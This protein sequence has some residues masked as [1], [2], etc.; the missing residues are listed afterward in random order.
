MPR[1]RFHGRLDATQCAPGAMIYHPHR[2]QV[3]K[4]SRAMMRQSMKRRS[5]RTGRAIAAAML[6]AFASMAPAGSASA[7]DR[8]EAGFSC[9][10]ARAT[11]HSDD[12]AL[13]KR[14]CRKVA[15]AA[16]L[17]KRCEIMP[18]ERIDISIVQSTEGVAGHPLAISNAET[19]ET[20][21]IHP[22][23]IADAFAPKSPYIGLPPDEVFDSL[24]VHEVAHA[25]LSIDPHLIDPHL[26]TERL[27]V[28]EYIA[29]AFQISSMDAEARKV[30]LDRYPVAIPV[31]LAE[32]NMFAL[33]SD[34]VRFGVKA[35]IHYSD[36]A[37]GCA[38]VGE[39]L[40]GRIR[41]PAS[42]Y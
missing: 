8:S 1:R 9:E 7:D 14:V 32:F 37:N 40:S 35:W 17:L 6:G 27:L 25:V 10:V 36:P 42:D 12:R 28:H 3:R 31:N 18:A 22:A 5:R 19:K 41:F 23:M 34:P 11:V 20:R 33:Q 38:F 16:S 21:I 2:P 4:A 13:A 39:I 26:G 30:L 15:Q 24:V 29:H